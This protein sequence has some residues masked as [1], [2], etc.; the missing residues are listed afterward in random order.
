MPPKYK[1]IPF[2]MILAPFDWDYFLILI[3]GQFRDNPLFLDQ[4][5]R[6][7][8]YVDWGPDLAS[9]G[10][11]SNVTL[12]RFWAFWLHVLTHI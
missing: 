6:Y 5:T 2:Q 4:L 10:V 11:Y 3:L 12:T 1:G 7:Q 9:R 8:F